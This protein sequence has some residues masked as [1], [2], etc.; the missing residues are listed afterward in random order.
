[1]KNEH[2]MRVVKTRAN[3]LNAFT[4]LL[5]E[6]PLAEIKVKEICDRACCSRNTFYAHFPYKEA[7]LDNLVEDCVSSIVRSTRAL[8]TAIEDVDEDIIM[9][10]NRNIIHA[11][12]ASRDKILF[13]LQ[14]GNCCDF[15]KRLSEAVYN[16]FLQ[17]SMKVTPGIS[18]DTR[19]SAYCRYLS[20]GTVNFILHWIKHPEVTEEEAFIMLCDMHSAPSRTA[21]D[22]LIQ[23]AQNNK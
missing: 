4:A 7:V 13:L 18:A 2:D 5:R 16:G 8:V 20:G 3:I 9:R 22:Y 11:A 6:K 14:Y 21:L 23:Y 15:A 12:A 10:Y 17:N 19:Y 1:M